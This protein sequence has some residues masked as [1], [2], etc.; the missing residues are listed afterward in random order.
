MPWATPRHDKP[1]VPAQ[2]AQLGPVDSGDRGPRLAEGWSGQDRV[3]DLPPA[4]FV[5]DG[6][7]ETPV[8]LIDTLTHRTAAEGRGSVREVDLPDAATELVDGIGRI[9][10]R[11]RRHR[12]AQGERRR[13][14]DRRSARRPRRQHQHQR[15]HDRS[16]SRDERAA[17]GGAKPNAATP[18]TLG[19]D[20]RA[21]R[22]RRARCR[23]G[24]VDEIDHAPLSLIERGQL[25]RI[26]MRA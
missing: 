26:G 14:T 19:L 21:Q 8:D 4:P 25:N 23:P 10:R 24:V 16:E 18:P 12:S 15:Q 3:R 7:C 17:K 20:P 13:L 5:V 2:R 9:S 6:D 22:R 11:R 1:T